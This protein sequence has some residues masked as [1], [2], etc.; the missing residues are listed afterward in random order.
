MKTKT[1]AIKHARRNVR[2]TAAG[3]TQWRVDTYSEGLK[4]W[5]EG[6]PNDWF[7]ARDAYAQALIDLARHFMGKDLSQYYGGGKWQSYI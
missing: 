1:A 4:V 7:R 2:L 3:I 5:R 6:K